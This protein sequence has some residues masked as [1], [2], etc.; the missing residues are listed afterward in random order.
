MTM[1]SSPIVLLIY[2]QLLRLLKM[3]FYKRD[4]WFI[5]DNNIS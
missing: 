3:F 1:L 2:L 4:S 5:P